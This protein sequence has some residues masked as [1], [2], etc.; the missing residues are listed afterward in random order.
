MERGVILAEKKKHKGHFWMMLICCAVMIGGIFLIG[1][2]GSGNWG[3]LFIL[4]CPLMHIF[5][6]KGH[7][8]HNDHKEDNGENHQHHH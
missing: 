2:S 7:M 8:G 4:L 3:I 1:R 5:M 6:M